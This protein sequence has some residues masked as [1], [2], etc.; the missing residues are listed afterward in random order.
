MEAQESGSSVPAQPRAGLGAGKIILIVLGA[1]S[2]LLGMALAGGGGV[3]L[4]AQSA[5]RDAQGFFVAGPH[6]ITSTGYAV[7]SERL[8][9]GINPE[10]G[11][12]QIGG[13][14]TL[15][16]RVV[17]QRPQ[18]IFVGIGP[19]SDV[20]AYLENSAHD[21]VTD[22]QLDP[23]K[24][25]Y[26]DVPGDTPPGSPGR[27]SFWASQ[28]SGTGEQTVVWHP[29]NGRWTVVIMNEDGS[30]VVNARM[31]VGVRVRFLTW[32]AIGLLIAAMLAFIAG[33]LM[34]YF[35][36]RA[37]KRLQGLAPMSSVPAPH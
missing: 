12:V 6:P 32:I 37:P 20:D 7:T 36:V 35:G 14:F 27:E 4:F 24:A 3:V 30:P 19:S 1:V 25:S 28:Q 31:S 22:V 10:R 18:P 5:F 2:L 26:R 29:R 33:G 34:L 11:S 23:Y 17:S 15:R 13:I 9:L 8:D 21:E 16:L